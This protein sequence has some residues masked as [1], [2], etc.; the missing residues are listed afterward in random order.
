[1]FLPPRSVKKNNPPSGLESDAPVILPLRRSSSMLFRRLFASLFVLGLLAGLTIPVLAQDK[2]KDKAKDK[3]EKKD[4]D[5]KDDK[6]DKDKKDKEEP[7]KGDAVTLKWK[8]EK[9]K[10]FYQ[11]MST[12]TVQTMKVMNNDVNQT[13][14]Q[15]FYFKWKVTK[16]E[17][18]KATLEQEIAGVKMD[19]DIGGTKIA[20][21]STAAQQAN[22]PLGD[23]FKALVGSKFTVTLDTTK[24]TVTDMAGREDFIKKLVA[25]NPGMR[26]LLDTILSQEALKEM[27]EPTFAVVPTKPVTAGE[28]WT[29]KTTLDMGPIGKYENTYEYTYEKVSEKGLD[30]I[31][32]KT[33][34]NYVQPDEKTGQGGLPFKIKS[35]KLKS[36]SPVGQVFFDNKKGRVQNS[37]M[38]LELKGDLSIEIGGQTTTVNLSQTQE[39]TTETSDEDPLAKK[40][41]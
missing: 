17:S 31:A 25:A 7:K 2:D 34:L 15:T 35:A 23:F 39:S 3:D 37:T 9:D 29:K 16:V 13:Q 6:K 40:K 33:T 38:K 1:L 32:V 21:D 36:S 5:K 4:K 11:T 24:Y 26:Q 20:Y 10:V 28:K 41:G 19:I 30:Q 14:N 12:K 27:A 8:F 18:D 22:N